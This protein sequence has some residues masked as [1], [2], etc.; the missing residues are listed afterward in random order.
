MRG[1]GDVDVP[2]GDVVPDGVVDEIGDEDF[3]Q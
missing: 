2:A 1:G 3:S